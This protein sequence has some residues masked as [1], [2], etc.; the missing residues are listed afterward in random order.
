MRHPYSMKNL[1]IIPAEKID[2]AIL[3]IRGQE[4][5]LLKICI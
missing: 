4:V 3:L 5:M 2:R 1:A